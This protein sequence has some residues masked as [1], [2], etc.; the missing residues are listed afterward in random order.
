MACVASDQQRTLSV[1]S[2]H[3]INSTGVTNNI[4]WADC[5]A[6]EAFTSYFDV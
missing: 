4:P 3:L 2:L 6:A 5:Q 1:C